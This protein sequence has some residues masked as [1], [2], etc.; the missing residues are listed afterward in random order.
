MA[1]FGMGPYAWLRDPD[2]PPPRVGYNIADTV[3]GFPEEYGVS[4]RLQKKFAKWV[5]EFENNYH[6]EN[7][8]WKRFNDEGHALTAELKSQIG[9]S[10][11]FEYHCP[12]ESVPEG[13]TP[14]IFVI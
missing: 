5:T 11:N 7:F 4:K 1:D 9:D 3:A 2:E 8:D 14:E 10:F 12:C 13:E 6:D